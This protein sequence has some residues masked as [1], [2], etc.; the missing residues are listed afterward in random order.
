MN[1]VGVTGVRDPP[2]ARHAVPALGLADRSS[3]RHRRRDRR[4]GWQTGGHPL[5]EARSG[6]G[7]LYVT[8]TGGV[9]VDA[10]TF[11][12]DGVADR[13]PPTVSATLNPAAPDGENGWYT[14]NVTLT[15]TATDNGTVSS[16]QYSIDGGTTWLNAANPVTLS[17]EGATDVRVPG[18]R[19]RRQRY[20][21][22]APSRRGSTRPRR[23]CR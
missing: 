11:V 8:S 4:S 10:F 2:R 5:A 14:G 20:R 21:R 16:R 18:D 1:F 19:Q 6:S 7:Q 15:V 22:S 13:T 12:G 23:P 17:A 9:D 3:V